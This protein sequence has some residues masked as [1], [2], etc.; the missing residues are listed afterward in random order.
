MSVYHLTGESRID[1]IGQEGLK[2]T[3]EALSNEEKKK[4]E[5]KGGWIAKRFF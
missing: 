5:E 3:L 1:K 4:I 2:P